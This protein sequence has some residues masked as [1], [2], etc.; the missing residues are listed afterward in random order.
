MKRIICFLTALVMLTVFP[1]EQAF[2]A[3]KTLTISKNNISH[4][5]SEDLYGISLEDSSYAGDGGLVSNLVNNGSFEMEDKAEAAWAFDNVT[6]VLSLDDPL[7]GSNPSY[8]TLKIDGKGAITNNGF[9]ELYKYKTYKYDEQL[10]AKGDMGFKKGASYDF[11]CYIKNIDFNGTISV[12]L[13]SK[14]NRST[15]IQ[16]PTDTLKSN[17]W[18]KIDTKLKSNADE[19]GSLTIRFDGTGTLQIDFVSLVPCDSYGYSDS[20]WKYVSLRHDLVETLKNLNPSFIRFPGGCLT[21]G[22]SLDRLYSW[23]NTI[24]PLEERRQCSNVWSNPDNGN[25]YNNTSAMGYHEY[26][27]L[28]E[29]LGAE[30]IPVVNAGITCQARNGYEDYA[31]ALEKSE[32]SDEEWNAYLIN[33]KGYNKNDSTGIEER[34]KYIDSLDI[35][36]DR[37]FEAYLDTIALRPGTEE[38][39]NY[40]QD[41]LDLIEYA[42]GDSTTTYWGAQRAANGHE[43]PFDITY[44]GIGNENWGDVYF[45]N[46]DAIKKMI[47]D[48]YPNITVISSSGAEADGGYFDSAWDT[49]SSR[50]SDIVVDEHYTAK[51]NYLM[52]H[53]DRYDSYDRNGPAVLVGEYTA[54]APGSGALITKSNIYSATE[55][56]GYMTGFERNSDIVK[57]TCCAPAM[58]KINANSHDMNM[59]W[60]DSHQ[61]VL[62][63]NYYSRMLFA[64][65]VGSKYIDTDL[66]D[67]EKVY[68]SVTV[69][70]DSQI[71]YIKLVNCNASGKKISIKLDGFDS[72]NRV[73][74]QN[75]SHRYKTASNQLNNQTIAPDETD[76]K[77]NKSSFNV[78]MSAYSVNVIRVAYGDNTGTSLYS[79]P[80]SI[81]MD[82]KSYMPVYV[83]ILLAVTAVIFAGAGYLMYTRT[84]PRRRKKK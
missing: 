83:K 51:N 64:N 34:T 55:E 17:K 52:E 12:L 23:K 49:I 33:E 5:V 63:P 66:P 75:I 80:D 2:A 26:F 30:P 40:V 14:K 44:I 37:D 84:T 68:H 32:M 6:A 74:N 67:M 38:F 60:F 4:A 58:A 77:H 43:A 76:L 62:T 81:N 82:T 78:K 45:R 53:N 29:D 69:D 54:E 36:S 25:Y 11:S 19:D 70:E 22:T 72:I 59:I 56:A 24:G 18:Q 50:Y 7:N 20:T 46:F 15:A 31:E 3:D 47:S 79:L 27:Q 39:Y 16:L 42:N 8:E 1:A 71:M 21:E 61:V 10:A 48:R 13:D 9:S 57:M 35:K 28:S 65:N 73:S 41:I